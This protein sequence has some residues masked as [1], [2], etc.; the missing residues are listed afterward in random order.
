MH[1]AIAALTA[2]GVPIDDKI[3]VEQLARD[4]MSDSLKSYPSAH[5]VAPGSGLVQEASK[6]VELP[7][8]Q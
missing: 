7:K 6:P 3:T 1:A 5:P 4:F 8:P 2:H